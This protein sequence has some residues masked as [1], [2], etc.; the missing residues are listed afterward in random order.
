M[1]K[2]LII[3]L[4]LPLGV[5]A[6]IWTKTYGGA[7]DDYANFI[8]TTHD[9][10]YIIVGYT[11]SFG[12]GDYDI[13]V[14][15]IDT[16][17][18][19]IWTKTYGD[20]VDEYGYCIR[21]VKNGFVI[22]GVRNDILFLMKIDESGN[23]LWEKEYH[24]LHCYF[25]WWRKIF[26][27]D[28][29]G[30]YILGGD[31][32]IED[33]VVP[34]IAKID[35]MGYIKWDKIYPS[36]G[37]EPGGVSSIVRTSSLDYAFVTQGYE[38]YFMKVDSTGE[39][40]WMH[41]Y[42]PEFKQFYKEWLLL[43]LSEYKPDSFLV[44]GNYNAYVGGGSQYGFA[45]IWEVDSE[46][47][48]VFATWGD[49]GDCAYYVNNYLGSG[50][51]V[52][53]RKKNIGWRLDAHLLKYNN[54]KVTQKEYG[55]TF[56][57]CATCFVVLQNKGIILVG[58]TDS[59]DFGGK[60]VWVAKIDSMLTGTQEHSI[61]ESFT[62]RNV[63][64]EL[65]PIPTRDRLSIFMAGS[66]HSITIYDISGRVIAHFKY[67]VRV[68]DVRNY[69]AGVYFISVNGDRRFVQKFVIIK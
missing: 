40:I 29:N 7:G 39:P 44:V 5:S 28:R 64:I 63:K 12:K 55:T 26:A 33:T 60:D 24:E 61:T 6:N 14:L 45:G 38:P 41:N 2:T 17:G 18:D 57:E 65:H 36:Y 15:K 13:W 3:L 11:N 20:T 68:I 54:G 32:V 8:D 22:L 49:E 48:N 47:S 30:G 69:P 16:A 1:C 42:F 59:S 66:P 52:V 37:C 62:S 51:L 9:G 27:V 50:V 35:S 19:T 46:T 34:I 23:I 25:S 43:S 58:Y 4:M 53:G 10:N 56:N 31:T 67:P 21:S